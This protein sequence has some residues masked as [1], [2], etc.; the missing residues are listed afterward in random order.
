MRRWDEWVEAE[1]LLPCTSEN[2]KKAQ[3]ML[4]QAGIKKRG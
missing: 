4:Q 3:D 1:S 2:K